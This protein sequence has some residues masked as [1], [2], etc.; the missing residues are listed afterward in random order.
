MTIER[1]DSLSLSKEKGKGLLKALLGARTWSEVPPGQMIYRNFVEVLD[2]NTVEVFRVIH[3]GN[4]GMYP[5]GEW[6]TIRG[7]AINR[8]LK[9]LRVRWIN[10]STETVASQL[11]THSGPFSD[12]QLGPRSDF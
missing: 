12:R 3:P 10:H 9:H 1:Q 11:N 8:N 6:T 4:S 5:L 7:D 2:E